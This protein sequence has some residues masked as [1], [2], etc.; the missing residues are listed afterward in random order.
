MPLTLKRINSELFKRGVR[1]EEA[2]GYFY[3][4]G[5]E[6]AN[7]LDR[8]VRVP[9][10][11]SL[12]LE[13]W[14]GKFERLQ[15]SNAQIMKVK[16]VRSKRNSFHIRCSRPVASGIFPGVILAHGKAR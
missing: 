8:T 16:P 6:A 12:T 9:K 7:W 1:L 5:G 11:S 4:I 3:F 15:K 13:Q 10:V 2:S 14:V